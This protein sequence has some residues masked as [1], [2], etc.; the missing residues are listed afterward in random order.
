MT[1]IKRILDNL[2]SGAAIPGILSLLNAGIGLIFGILIVR[3]LGPNDYG[4]YGIAASIFAITIIFSDLGYSPLSLREVP[5]FIINNDKSHLKG[6]LDQAL[7]N[8]LLITFCVCLVLII[9]SY[10]YLKEVNNE[11][12]F[13]LSAMSLTLITYMPYQFLSYLV[14]ALKAPNKYYFFEITR[15]ILVSILNASFFYMTGYLE[16]SVV[17]ILFAISNICIS[18]LIIIFLKSFNIFKFKNKPKQFNTEWGRSGLNYIALG[19]GY[20]VLSNTDILVLGYY[21][22]NNEVA[23]YKLGLLISGT[24]VI[25]L[26]GIDSYLAP[27]LS[28]LFKQEKMK[29]LENLSQRSSKITTLPILP[30]FIVFAFYGEKIVTFF[31]G[32]EYLPTMEV[33]LILIV[34]TACRVIFGSVGFIINMSGRESLTATIFWLGCI[35]N[36]ILNIIF[37]PWIGS[38][39]AAVA[40]SISLFIIYLAQYI[41]IRIVLRI[42]PSYLLKPFFN[43]IR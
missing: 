31:F 36:F 16:P 43:K 2:S 4:T 1:Q 15:I 19:A 41:Y 12:F 10:W 37:V 39:G 35:F 24:I 26:S 5:R 34:G 28:E 6:F 17:F 23:F 9:F 25:F 13:A 18:I 27:R 32:D 21:L 22:T 7:K 8:I 38:I 40:T 42:Q 14:R 29:E 33:L 30:F 11:L 20:I 3:L